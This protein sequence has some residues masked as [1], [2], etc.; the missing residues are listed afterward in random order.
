MIAHTGFLI[1]AR[2]IEPSEDE[3][4]RALLEEQGGV[5]D[6]EDLEDSTNPIQT[7]TL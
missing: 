1:F 2:R 4:A 7:E 5:T 3:R 6:E